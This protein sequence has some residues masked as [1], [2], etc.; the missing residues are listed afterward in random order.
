MKIRIIAIIWLM[1]LVMPWLGNTAGIDKAAFLTKIDYKES[2]KTAE[3]FLYIHD[4]YEFSGTIAKDPLRIVIDLK[5]VIKKV[6]SSYEI[7]GN[8]AKG[9]R[10]SQ[11]HPTPEYITRVV[12]DLK[13]ISVETMDYSLIKSTGALILKIEVKNKSEEKAST[14]KVNEPENIASFEKPVEPNEAPP[15]IK[16]MEIMQPNTIPQAVSADDEYII[17]PE[18]LLEI[19][20]F[21]LPDL[22]NTV[23]VLSNGK[24]NF[25]P[26]GDI[27]V[28]GLT[29]SQAEKKLSELLQKNF[30]NNA[31]V[32]VFIKEFKSQKVD[33]IGAVRNPGKYSLLGPKTVLEMLSEAGGL[34]EN[35]G[36][37]LIIFRRH[38]T[39]T[40]KIEINIKQLL[41]N[42]K[43]NLNVILK[44]G[45]VVNIPPVG[46]LSIYVYGE[47]NQ[48]GG[49]D[50]KNDG[51]ATILKAIAKAGGP[52]DRANM[53]KVL[54]KR[55]GANGKELTVKANVKDIINGKIKDILVQEGDVIIVPESFF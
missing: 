47:V 34:S 42:G 40:T 5:P 32:I 11:Y 37:K 26:L 8:Y 38:S 45:D 21:E 10:I 54:I 18:D 46:T 49:I 48:P 31:H 14:E 4:M 15:E 1:W 6:N 22:S 44:P 50:L 27:D 28:N 2:G 19:R 36:D 29:K 17:G 52:T 30:I 3:L 41:E 12:V 25:P 7:K 55:M 24:I 16:A 23:R 35:S 33:I 9:L 43:A 53:R 20:V 13:N 39:E 51:N